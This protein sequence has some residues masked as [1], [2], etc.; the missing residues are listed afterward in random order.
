MRVLRRYSS[1]AGVSP[2]GDGLN[3]LSVA[4]GVTRIG[5]PGVYMSGV[6]YKTLCPF[7]DER[8]ASAAYT[9]DGGFVCHACGVKGNLFKLLKEEL[10]LDD[11]GASQRYHE[12]TGDIYRPVSRELSR[13][14]GREVLNSKRDYERGSELFPP[15]FRGR[16]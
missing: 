5:I 1:T 16:P 4:V 6:W 11:V 10:N 9:E 2:V 7:H 8:I 13:F 15:W 3:A 14:P 12:I